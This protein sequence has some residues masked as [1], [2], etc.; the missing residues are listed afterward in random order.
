MREL[1]KDAVKHLGGVVEALRVSQDDP[2]LFNIATPGLQVDYF[3]ELVPRDKV[4]GFAA[5]V[6]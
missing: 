1:T 4:D 6:G 2:I 5:F 3:R